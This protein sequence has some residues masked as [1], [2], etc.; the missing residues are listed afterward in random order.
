MQRLHHLALLGL[1]LILLILPAA[2]TPAS[3]PTPDEPTTTALRL[4][5]DA[6]QDGAKIV[7]SVKGDPKTHSADE[8]WCVQTDQNQVGGNLPLLFVVWRVGATW[9]GDTLAEGFYD[10]DAQGCPR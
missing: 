6:H 7:Q 4:I 10:W 9:Q 3:S 2:C 5:H 8:L 1:T